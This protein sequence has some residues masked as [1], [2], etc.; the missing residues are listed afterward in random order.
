M[1]AGGAQVS[2]HGQR[3]C[4]DHK[5]PSRRLDEVCSTRGDH[6]TVVQSTVIAQRTFRAAAIA[7]RS[8]RAAE[9][10]KWVGVRTGHTSRDLIAC[11]N[12]DENEGQPNVL[13]LSA[14][15]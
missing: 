6:A 7:Q 10:K 4:D 1:L 3:G 8:C 12:E 2:E 9:A 11:D 15:A 13:I 5:H 14:E